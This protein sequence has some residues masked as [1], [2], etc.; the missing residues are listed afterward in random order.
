VDSL[1]V[2]DHLSIK[3]MLL[4]YFTVVKMYYWLYIVG[5]QTHISKSF[6]QM[7]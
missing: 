5:K 4:L 7:H 6:A 1:R 3:Y 2:F